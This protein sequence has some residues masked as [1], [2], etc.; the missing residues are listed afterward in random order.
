MNKVEKYLD[1]AKSKGLNPKHLDSIISV[2]MRNFIKEFPPLLALKTW[3]VSIVMGVLFGAL[4]Y[5]FGIFLTKLILVFMTN[6]SSGV[7]FHFNY[8]I[9]IIFLSPILF[10]LQLALSVKKEMLKVDMPSWEEFS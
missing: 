6:N 3:K 10:G 5:P 7:E 9:L 1:V 8:Y 4:I 2:F